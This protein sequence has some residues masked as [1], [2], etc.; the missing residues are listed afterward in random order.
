[1]RHIIN[2]LFLFSLFFVLTSSQSFDLILN[3][4]ILYLSSEVYGEGTLNYLCG[5]TSYKVNLTNNQPVIINCTTPLFDYYLANNNIY[6]VLTVASGNTRY[7]QCLL[8]INVF[9]FYY[10]NNWYIVTTNTN[11]TCIFFSDN[12]PFNTALTVNSYYLWSTNGCYNNMIELFCNNNLNCVYG[13]T[14]GININWGLYD[15][16]E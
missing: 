7:V 16:I 2:I 9:N 10:N 12:I 14:P 1:M 11:N 8:D 4:N 15:F 6:S 5:S 13:N 3:N